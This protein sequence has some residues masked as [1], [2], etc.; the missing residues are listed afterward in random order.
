MSSR[1]MTLVFLALLGGVLIGGRV[2]P[3]S[4]PPASANAPLLP[5]PAAT[6]QPIPHTP[7]PPSPLPFTQEGT[8]VQVVERVRPAIVN[9]DTLA[10]VKTAMGIFPQK[11][12]GS[13]VIV[14]PDGYIL[15]NNHVVEGAEQIRV[16]LLSGRAFPG[17]VV[18]ADRYSDLTVLKIAAPGPLPAAE[19]GT[20]GTLRVGQLAMA[21]GNPFGLGSTVTV[22]V[23]SALNRS[24]QAPGMVVENLIQTD[25]AINP[26]NSGGALVDSRGDVVGINTAII[27]EAQGIGFAIPI[28]TA[29][30]IM[31]QLISRGRVVRPYAGLV[32]GGDVDR[33]IARQYG[34]PVEYG[35]I[36]RGVDPAGPAAAAGL[37]AGDV[38]VALDSK[39]T[40]TWND[41]VRELLEITLTERPRS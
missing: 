17:R 10:E 9:I 41:F 32:W 21:I 35:V 30:A 3:F 25:A 11:G 16:T 27:P 2:G 39:R 4:S 5:P 29:R 1:T 14:S 12:A 40:N 13:G 36:I 20:S 28:D 8:V 6:P 33:E 23:I 37:R 22:G 31:Q 15:T 19:L 18:G 7:P 24:V 26:G 34:L 38:M